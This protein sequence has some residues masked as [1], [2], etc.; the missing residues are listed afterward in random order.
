M[1]RHVQFGPDAKHALRRL[2]AEPIKRK[3]AQAHHLLLRPLL[4]GVAHGIVHA[5]DD[6][7]ARRLE[8]EVLRCG[9][10]RQ[11]YPSLDDHG[12]SDADVFRLVELLEGQGLVVGFV[13]RPLFAREVVA[14]VRSLK[15]GLLAEAVE[16][17]DLRSVVHVDED[18]R[19][20][21]PDADAADPAV[22][23]REL[24][25]DEGGIP[26]IEAGELDERLGWQRVVIVF[27]ARCI[28][29][30]WLRRRLYLFCGYCFWLWLRHCSRCFCC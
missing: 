26:V 15:G 9:G 27:A 13:L 3:A 2:G 12:A 22:E 14:V 30:G 20:S 8:L 28:V 25:G 6:A 24:V 1:H 4:Q 19:A 21:P 11:H 29:T 16:R 10:G 7:D 17:S 5:A 23:G 18:D